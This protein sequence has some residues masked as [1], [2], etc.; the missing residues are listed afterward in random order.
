MNGVNT[1]TN[2]AYNHYGGSTLANLAYT[3]FGGSGGEYLTHLLECFQLSLDTQL[4]FL[5]AG[6]S[7]TYTCTFFLPTFVS[8]NALSIVSST[9]TTLSKMDAATN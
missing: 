8:W 5:L 2:L 6:G 4:G 7:V 3:D 9:L 1:L